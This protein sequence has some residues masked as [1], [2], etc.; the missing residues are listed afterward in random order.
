MKS[1]SFLLLLAFVACSSNSSTQPLPTG[2]P[3][4]E[5]E[6]GKEIAKVGGK[7]IREGYLNVLAKINPRLQAQME[8]PMAKKQLVDNLLEQEMMYEESVKR[9]IDREKEVTQKAALYKRVII[10]QALLEDELEKKAKEYYEKNKENEF[11]KVEVSHIQ[12][13][14][15]QTSEKPDDKKK[16]PAPTAA[17][18][19]SALAK[20]KEVKAKIASGADFAKMV[21][22]YSDD[23]ISKKK[24]GSMGAV[25]KNDKR[26]ARRGMD[27]AAEMVFKM[28]KGEVSDPVESKKGY[29]LLTVTADPQVTPFEEALKVIRFQIQ[30]EVKDGLLVNLKKEYKIVYLD[31]TLEKPV[32]APKTPELTAPKPPAPEAE[33]KDQVFYKPGTEMRQGEEKKN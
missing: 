22:E 25:S 1:L 17:E 32:E 10:A 16:E 29:H 28:K 9:G 30:K 12:F 31:K 20:A 11:A 3:L 15:K 4:S 23:K 19:Q 2:D 33:K 26:L 6:Q 5:I 8:N 13:N 18:K 7:V 21:E 24:A 14:F 27:K